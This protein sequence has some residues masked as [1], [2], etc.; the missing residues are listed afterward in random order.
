MNRRLLTILTVGAAASL[1]A[2]CSALDTDEV[3]AVGDATLSETELAE[4]GALIGP[5]AEELP[6]A[7]QAN[8][9]R[10]A[11]SVWLEAQ[12]LTQA[13]TDG[14]NELDPALVDQST[15]GLTSQFPEAF[16]ALSAAT[17]DLLVD[18]VTVIDQLPSLPRPDEAEVR[19]WF[20]GGPQQSGLACISH[21]L[22]ETEDA[23]QD[24]VDEL[25][26]AESETAEAELFASI[27]ME[28]SIDPGSGAVGGFLS[29]LTSENVSQQF[30]PTFGAAALAAEP[31]E[32][33]EPVE[34]DFGFHVLRLQTFDEAGDQL[35]QFYADGYVQARIA[36]DGADVSVDSRYGVADGVNVVAP[37]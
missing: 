14:G 25:G 24:I 35:E 10:T 20:D 23:A 37:V 33:T 29:C 16:P 26:E 6:A 22:V 15:Q 13:Y 19:A 18:Y 7:D 30:V 1:V 36:I 5:G 28:R 21:I 34:S 32:P 12:V 11:I 4:L 2:G 3:A 17:R 8:V 27:A 9:D 31:G